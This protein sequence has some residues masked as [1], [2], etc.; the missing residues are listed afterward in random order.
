MRRPLASEPIVPI[1]LFKNRAYAVSILIGFIMSFGMFGTIIFVPLV[2]QGV[3]GISATNSGALITPLMFGL[4]GAMHR[5]RPAD[6][7]HQALPVPWARSA[8][9]SP[10]WE[11]SCFLKFPFTRPSSK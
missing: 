7:A 2:Y 9:P 8:Q 5:H 3:L 1:D 10:R 6:G 4:I 11:C